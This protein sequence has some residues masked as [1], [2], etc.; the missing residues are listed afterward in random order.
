MSAAVMTW[1]AGMTWTATTASTFWALAWP[2]CCCAWLIRKN[3]AATGHDRE[4]DPEDDDDLASPAVVPEFLIHALASVVVVVSRLRGL[5]AAAGGVASTGP[6]ARRPTGACPRSVSSVGVRCGPEV[7]PGGPSTHH[8]PVIVARPS[9]GKSNACSCSADARPDR[10]RRCPTSISSPRSSRPATSPAAIERLNDGLGRRPPPPDAAG[11][12]RH[13][14]DV[15]ARLG[16]RDAQQADARPGPQ[17][18]ARR[19]AVRRVPRVLPE[20]RG[21]VLRQLLRLLPA[22]GLPAAQRHVHREG[23]VAQRRDRPAAARRD[24]R[25][26]RAPR[27]DHR[28]QRLVHLRPGRAGRLRRDRPQAADRRQV[29][30]RR[31]A[32]P[33]GRPPVPAQRPGPR[34]RPVPRPRRHAGAPAGLGG[35]R[36][37]G[38]VLRRR[39]RAHH[40]DRSAD[41]RAAGRAQGDQRLSGHAL[42]DA[43][44]TSSRKRSST[45]RPRWRSGSAQ[46]E[47]EGRALEARAAA[48]AHDVRP[49]DAARARL[50]LGRREL[51]APPRPA[52]GRVAAV[53]AARLLPAGL[54]AGRRRVAHDDPAGRRH[55][56]E[57]P[58][59][60]GDPGRLRVPAAVG[61][62]QPAADVRGVRGDGQPGHLH[63]RDARAVR[64]GT[65]RGPHRPAAH[66]PDRASST[67]RSRSA[68]PTA[69]STTCSSRSGRGSSAASASS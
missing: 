65:Q 23:L 57:R 39:G 30:A 18:D 20:Q 43:R 50:L 29:P 58:D 21:R 5:W 55:V 9:S 47:A 7:W 32:A 10:L 34:P 38:R 16:H 17:Q 53:D 64:A 31:R 11:R 35:D 68:R 4:D 59:P 61:A 14:Q 3:A 27:R 56:Q 37:P 8:P 48:P 12:H 2:A 40:R 69:R 6:W 52:R 15:H 36:R 45:S 49:G 26:V 66:P 19:A 46:L 63:E 60:Q 44:R 13:R 41:R 67:R 33:P 51:L 1:R 28:G 54:A 25:P 22:R 42:R 62:R 24:A